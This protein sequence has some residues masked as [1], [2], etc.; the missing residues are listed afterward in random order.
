MAFFDD[1]SKK[2]SQGTKNF[3]DSARLNG[4]IGENRKKI[5]KLYASLGQ[6]YYEAHR[7]DAAPEFPELME[8]LN[9]LFD[10]IAQAEDALRQLR[11]RGKCPNCGAETAQNALFCAVCGTK[12]PQPEPPTPAGPKFCAV[13]G[14]PLAPGVRFCNACGNP[15]AQPEKPAAEPEPAPAEPE[16][17]PAEEP[18]QTPAAPQSWTFPGNG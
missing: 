16:P 6:R 10:G 7:Q 2:V 15:V 11:Q 3:A 13:C 12:L 18:E 5:E 14:N 4:V 8:E 17:A 9:A 1:L